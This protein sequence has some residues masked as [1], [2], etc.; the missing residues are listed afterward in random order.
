MENGDIFMIRY[1]FASD[2]EDPGLPAVNLGTPSG[3]EFLWEKTRNMLSYIY[4]RYADE[5]DWF[6]KADDD[7]YVIVDNLRSFLRSKDPDMSVYFGCR[8]RWVKPS[9]Q[10][11]MSGGAGYVLSKTA[12]RKFVEEALNNKTICSKSG[13]YE[14]VEVGLCLEN[15][16]VEAGDTR[17]E[18]QRHRWRN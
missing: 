17:D 8:I 12:L 1:V 11:Y 15:I 5:F 14:D 4:Q 3:R 10:G 18:Q 13:D 16:G 7:T 6:M 9:T 2:E